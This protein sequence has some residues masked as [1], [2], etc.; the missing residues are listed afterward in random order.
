MSESISQSSSAAARARAGA[1][2]WMVHTVP[3]LLAAAGPGPA[4]VRQSAF[5]GLGVLAQKHAASFRP[6]SAQAVQ[7]LLSLVRPDANRCACQLSWEC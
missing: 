1:A 3:L 2:E 6:V 4:Q 5:Y 7:A